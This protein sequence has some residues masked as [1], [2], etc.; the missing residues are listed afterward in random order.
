[1]VTTRRPVA[2]GGRRARQGGGGGRLL[3]RGVAVPVLIGF[4]LA[5]AGATTTARVLAGVAL[6]LGVIGI[7]AVNLTAQGVVGWPLGM[8][9]RKSVV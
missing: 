8:R 6:A 4:V 3:L 1:M 7:A 2:A 9:D 5:P